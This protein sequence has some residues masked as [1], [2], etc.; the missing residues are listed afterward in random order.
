[1]PSRPQPKPRWKE[2]S[3]GLKKTQHAYLTGNW[4]AAK[5]RY[6]LVDR[7]PVGQHTGPGTL[8]LP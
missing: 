1:M 2:V 6:G 5:L 3:F 8:W 7:W 4:P